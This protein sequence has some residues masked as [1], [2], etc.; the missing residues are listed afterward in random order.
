MHLFWHL[1]RLG[2]RNEPLY[3]KYTVE[4]IAQLKGINIEE[5]KIAIFENFKNLF[6]NSSNANEGDNQ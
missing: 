2:E 5:V 3:V 4:T 6:L 1:F